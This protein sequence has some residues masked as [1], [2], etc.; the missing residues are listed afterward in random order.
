[1][2]TP[3]LGKNFYFVEASPRVSEARSILKE[4]TRK[5]FCLVRQIGVGFQTPR[6]GTSKS[7]EDSEVLL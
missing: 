2:I 5:D 1:M 7:S 6:F 3:F 4:G